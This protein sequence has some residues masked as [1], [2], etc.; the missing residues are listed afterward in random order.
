M[1]SRLIPHSMTLPERGVKKLMMPLRFRHWGEGRD[2]L[3][4]TRGTGLCT[5]SCRHAL[6][7]FQGNTEKNVSR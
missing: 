6:T 2:G 4:G 3:R 1:A 5:S 7:A